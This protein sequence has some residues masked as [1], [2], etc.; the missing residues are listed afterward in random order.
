MIHC[1]TSDL[2]KS[3]KVCKCIAVSV[4]LKRHFYAISKVALHKMVLLAKENV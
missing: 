3:Q 2:N 1:L 4:F